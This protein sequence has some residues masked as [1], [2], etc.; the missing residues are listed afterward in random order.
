[1]LGARAASSAYADQ[2]TTSDSS[3]TPPAACPESTSCSVFTVTSVETVLGVPPEEACF[4]S[5]KISRMA[6]QRKTLGSS[7][8]STTMPH[9]TMAIVTS[10]TP[11]IPRQ[12]RNRRNT[13][14]PKTIPPKNAIP[15]GKTPEATTTSGPKLNPTPDND[16]TPA[17]TVI[18][19]KLGPGTS[20]T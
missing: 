15:K 10:R 2:F 18:A 9:G 17:A 14:T 16:T 1:M 8:G 19:E 5:T 7:P 3:P 20:Q 12:R 13:P 4:A 11:T 6:G